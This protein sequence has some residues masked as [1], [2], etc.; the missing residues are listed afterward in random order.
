MRI[1]LEVKAGPHQG[2]VFEFNERA[3]F[4]VGRSERANFRL[5]VKDNSI[6]RLHF[7]I[8]MNPPQCRLT[9]MEITNGTR[10]NGRK[11]A[12]ADLKNGDLI[13]A[14]KT[15]L[16]V[17]VI[18]S[19]VP[20]TSPTESLVTAA[21]V[22]FDGSLKTDHDAVPI[23]GPFEHVISSTHSPTE[24]RHSDKAPPLWERL[25]RE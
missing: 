5:A 14:G 22:E 12:I 4:I 19:D 6:S 24:R 2:Q 16:L 21:A 20:L 7:M 23:T 17:S 10:V 15:T 9:D 25:G 3:N 1:N 13:T 8:E 11:V 18:G